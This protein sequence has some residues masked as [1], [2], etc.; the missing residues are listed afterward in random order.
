MALPAAITIRA[1]IS[2]GKDGASAV[3][4]APA[5]NST[6]PVRCT[7]R[8]PTMS[9]SR[10]IGS[11]SALIVSACATTTHVTA[12]SVIPKSSAIAES[13]TKT[14]DMLITIVTN[15]MPIA[16]NANHFWLC[17]ACGFCARAVAPEVGGGGRVRGGQP[18]L[19]NLHQ[20]SGY[21][22]AAQVLAPTASGALPLASISFGHSTVIS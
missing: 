4:T 22:P 7:R 6:S 15:E 18:S 21:A 11:I 16:L 12:R 20:D 14:I 2:S 5:P 9:A 19:A 8:Q 13:A 1:T 3:S 10:P 17:G